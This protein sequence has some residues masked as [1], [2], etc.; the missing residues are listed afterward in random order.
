MVDSG[1]ES[2]IITPEVAE[3]LNAVKVPTSKVPL[4]DLQRRPYHTP[5]YAYKV[6]LP[7]PDGRPATHYFL[8]MPMSRPLILGMPW[9]RQTNPDIHWDSGRLFDRFRSRQLD[10]QRLPWEPPAADGPT[11]TD[12]TVP[13]IAWLQTRQDAAPT[14]D[15]PQSSTTSKMSSTCPPPIPCPPTRTLT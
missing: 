4:E 7:S 3:A 10:A 12:D 9:L 8:P 1:A 5:P 11:L 13:I 14:A 15:L 2:N 6:I